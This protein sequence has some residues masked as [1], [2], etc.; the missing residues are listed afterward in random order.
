MA[1]LGLGY[2]ILAFYVGSAGFAKSLSS[3]LSLASGT[4]SQIKGIKWFGLSISTDYYTA[5]NKT[6]LH[7]LQAKNM[8]SEISLASFYKRKWEIKKA[9]IS[10]LNLNLNFPKKELNAIPPNIVATQTAPKKKKAAQPLKKWELKSFELEDLRMQIKADENIFRTR[11]TKV[12]LKSLPGDQNYE[13]NARGGTVLSSIDWLPELHIG[14][15][16]G[17]WQGEQ[18]TFSK[19][20]ISGWNHA[21][22]QSQGTWNRQMKDFSLSGSITG[23]PC[24]DL[25]ISRD[26]PLITGELSTSFTL[27]KSTSQGELSLKHGKL[28]Y[29]SFFEFLG[30]DRFTHGLAISEAS[31]RW[32][33]ADNRWIFENVHMSSHDLMKLKGRI[34]MADEQI[35]GTFQLGLAKETLSHAPQTVR[36]LFALGEDGL[37]WT[38]LRLSGNPKKMK[39]DL[40][41]R[42]LKAS[43]EN[44][45]E[46]AFEKEKNT[47]RIE[48]LLKK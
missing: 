36:D 47:Q 11:G 16:E 25:F 19:I 21:E 7:S 20:I 43:L 2:G 3:K 32:S 9:R 5:K 30:N 6:F 40:T 8:H 29:L 15:I 41:K 45:L 34:I 42:L 12:S 22:L 10:Q 38:P 17:S 48:L 18:L 26:K 33:Y 23:V 13:Y 46:P 44:F 24:G 39:F 37:L 1:L 27:N 28:H 31:T 35:H 14:Q 4:E